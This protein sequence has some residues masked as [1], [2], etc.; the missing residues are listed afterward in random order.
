MRTPRA[1][2]AA[3]DERTGYTWLTFAQMESR[4]AY[5]SRIP[6]HAG[7]LSEMS[8]SRTNARSGIIPPGTISGATSKPSGIASRFE[9]TNE[10]DGISQRTEPTKQN[11]Q[12]AAPSRAASGTTKS[13]NRNTSLSSSLSSRTSSSRTTSNSSFSATVGPGSQP[14]SHGNPRPQTSFGFR[15]AGG[16]S[17]P[18]PATSLDTHDEDTSGSQVLGKRKGMQLSHKSH[19]HLS[20]GY[21]DKYMNYTADWSPRPSRLPVPEASTV[22]KRDTSLSAM[23]GNLTLTETQAPVDYTQN[24]CQTKK[25]VRNTL[26]SHV[27]KA[28]HHSR[29]CSLVTP[30]P[31]PTKHR[32]PQRH[33]PRIVPFLT[34]DS[35]TKAW[36]HE[37]R[38]QDFEQVC[39]ALFARMSQ[40]GQDSYGLKETVELYKSRGM[41][42]RS[43]E[44][45]IV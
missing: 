16:S 18:R 40:A 26:H 38:L 11:A 3:R 27:P 44:E 42:V 32:S 31:S 45:Q 5:K 29:S 14:P 39:D 8:L 37:S 22:R 34:K 41:C 7:S 24:P 35:N 19:F 12:T 28:L 6:T 13:H 30:S 1:R 25:Q 36:D 15:K 4:P 10:V 23:M 43:R 17:V 21:Y 2:Y 20:P 33:P 9:R